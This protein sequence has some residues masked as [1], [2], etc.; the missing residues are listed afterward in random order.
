MKN[1]IATI[2]LTI[3]VLLGSA[4]ESF[5]LPKCDGAYISNTWTN[6]EGTEIFASGKKYV[7]EWKDSKWHGQG[8][9]T[10]SNGT[11]NKG[12]WESGKFRSA[13]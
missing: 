6:C 11:V 3:A 2:C 9:Y 8:T 7:G 1:L 10:S 5:A 4:G 12:M 13:N